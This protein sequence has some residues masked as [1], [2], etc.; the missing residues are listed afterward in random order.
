MIASKNEES[1]VNREMPSIRLCEVRLHRLDMKTRFPFRYGI[2]SMTDAP[3]LFVLANV[4]VDQK[5]SR[6]I[7]ADGLPP[8]WFTKNINTTFEEDDLPSMLQVIR[9]AAQV[10]QDINRQPSFFAWWKALY[11]S[12]HDWATEK[13]I[14]QLLAGFGVSLIERAVLD[15]VCRG[16]G[17]SLFQ[18]FQ[19]N[20]LGIDFA[21][22]RPELRSRSPADVL[23]HQPAATVGLRHTVGLGDVL[24]GNNTPDVIPPDDDLP[25]TLEENIKAYGLRYFKIKLAG[26]LPTDRERL[27]EIASIVA[28]T[29]DGKARFTLDGNENYR[30]ISEFREAWSSLTESE[31]V[32]QFFDQSLLFVE[33]P[34]H[35]ENALDGSVSVELRAW[36]DAPPIIIDESDAELSSLPTAL[37]LGY[38]G[39]SHKNCKGIMKG[40]LN[41][42]SIH[43]ANRDGGHFIL[44]AED[45]GN[46]GP[47]ALLQ[48]LAMVA[49]LGISHVER[50]GHH[51]FAGLSMFPTPVQQEMLTHH[52]DLYTQRSEF[53]ALHPQQGLLSIGSI[54]AAPFGLQPMIA[55]EQFVEWN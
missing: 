6:G 25:F 19:R 26:D 7:S 52:G 18:V 51:Y 30:T 10:G 9:R 31:T 5:I 2:A 54:N 45:L 37:S 49:T 12:Q 8:K 32:R 48:D 14:P 33:Q 3:H 38:A 21:S 29:A 20:M 44:S 40:L 47:V 53:A 55:V 46:V 43:R 23:P 50:N 28:Q 42:A 41:A 39:T 4:E 11:E 13:N 16:L 35:R 1:L 17:N 27:E 36:S 24:S 34:V 15:A 22:V